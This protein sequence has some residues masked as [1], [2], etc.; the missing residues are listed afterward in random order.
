MSTYLQ[1]EYKERSTCSFYSAILDFQDLSLVLSPL[2]I[3]AHPTST[4]SLGFLIQRSS[5][6][7]DFL[8]KPE[9]RLGIL[10]V[11][12]SWVISA[13]HL[14][15]PVPHVCS[16]LI[17]AVTP[18]SKLLPSQVKREPLW[19]RR[20]GWHSI[21]LLHFSRAKL[22]SSKTSIMVSDGW[23]F[24]PGWQQE[25]IRF[26]NSHLAF[27]AVC[28]LPRSASSQLSSKPSKWPQQ[29]NQPSCPVQTG[30]LWGLQKAVRKPMGTPSGWSQRELGLNTETFLRAYYVLGTGKQT[31]TNQIPTTPCPH[32][33]HSFIHFKITYFLMSTKHEHWASLLPLAKWEALDLQNLGSDPSSVTY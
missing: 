31:E 14:G 25:G 10:M 3:H 9:L 19:G 30:L 2:H 11:T 6:I 29:Q 5:G 13:M 26:R 33:G 27:A 4:S 12:V 17:W 23:N 18:F 20:D 7:S 21:S 22:P 1:P 16:A 15:T 28:P 8:T 24:R 32:Q